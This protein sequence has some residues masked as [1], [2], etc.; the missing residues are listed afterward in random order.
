MTEQL[1]E[2]KEMNDQMVDNMRACLVFY[3]SLT[4]TKLKKKPE[5]YTIKEMLAIMEKTTK[6]VQ[7][8]YGR[9][10][11]RIIDFL[12]YFRIGGRNA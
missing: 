8:P 11:A 12:S 4:R 9:M 6:R 2:D 1:L 3:A 5:D 7:S 10:R